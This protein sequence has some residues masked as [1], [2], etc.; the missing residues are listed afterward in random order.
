M[1][2]KI[3]DSRRSSNDEKDIDDSA[4][5]ALA[6]ANANALDASSSGH[7]EAGP[8]DADRRIVAAHHTLQQD[9]F[10]V[11]VLKVI[12]YIPLK[13]LSIFGFNVWQTNVHISGHGKSNVISFLTDVARLF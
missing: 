2:E 9:G 10:L 12:F 3:D 8:S 1:G 11:R 7:E 5:T 4:G 13:V 6:A